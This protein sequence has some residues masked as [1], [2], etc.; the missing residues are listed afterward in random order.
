MLPTFYRD[1]DRE[2]LPRIKKTVSGEDA[3]DMGA[4]SFGTV[5]T[6]TLHLPRRLGAAAVVLRL[7]RD[8]EAFFDTPLSFVST[9][10]GEDRYELT[11]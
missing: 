9:K 3:S 5:I 10:Y 6:F 4:F 2:A 1:Y 11:L 7:C 8:G